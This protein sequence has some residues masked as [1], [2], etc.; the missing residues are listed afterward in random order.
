[1]VSGRETSGLYERTGTGGLAAMLGTVK[2]SWGGKR[3]T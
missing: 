2:V 1:M 3:V